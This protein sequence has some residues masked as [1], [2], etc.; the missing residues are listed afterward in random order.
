MMINHVTLIGRLTKNP[1]LRYTTVTG[2]AVATFTLAVNRSYTNQAGERETD[3]FLCV[4][5]KKRAEIIANH[6]QKGQ[7]VAIDGHLQ[8]RFYDTEHGRRYLT[9]IIVNQIQ[10]LE[11][12]GGEQI[13]S[14]I[15]E[16]EF[17]SYSFSPD[18][19]YPY[20]R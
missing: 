3:F 16:D 20:I 7:L 2:T 11:S 18:D 15:T 8:T 6:V 1:E 17:P 14:Q 12:K 19:D 13:F 9:E 10:F 5:W 4:A